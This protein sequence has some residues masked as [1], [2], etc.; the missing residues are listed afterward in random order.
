VA[1]RVTQCLLHLPLCL[2]SF[3][4]F[5]YVYSV[6]PMASIDT[7]ELLSLSTTTASTST[8]KSM[9]ASPGS[10]SM[11]VVDDKGDEEKIE[12]ENL[13]EELKEAGEGDSQ[14]GSSSRRVNALSRRETSRQPL[15][16][17]VLATLARF[18]PLCTNLYFHVPSPILNPDMAFCRRVSFDRQQATARA[19][20]LSFLLDKSTIYAKII[21]DRMARQQ[22][23]KQRAEQ[24][25]ATR[26]ENK[27]KKGD[28]AGG[29]EGMRK[30][31][32]AG[33]KDLGERGKRKRRSEGGRGEKRVKLEE[34][35]EGDPLNL[36]KA[37]EEHAED[38]EGEAEG[39]HEQDPD[40]QYSFEQPALVTG[41]KLRDY[42]LAGVQWMISLYENG[43]NG[44]LAD[45]MG[46][47][48][49]RSPN[50]TGSGSRPVD[51]ANH[52]L[53]RTSTSK[54][55]MGSI[56]HRLPLVRPEQLDDG[57]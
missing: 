41:A 25:A 17:F 36:R 11:T 54:G 33:E 14:V 21:G 56:P 2:L 5:P 10:G 4:I 30:K 9:P 13:V 46:L 52:R 38:G 49:V 23:E 43:L 26:K 22:I 53:P 12:A 55:H 35:G 18:P 1:L 48:K 27:E 28:L 7:S 37:K 42:Q 50:S 20:R 39:D 8:D 47:G 57:V 31:D 51:T 6:L 24:R 34:D 15:T 32:K 45:E 19:A 29:R 16:S 40:V 44:I 3:L